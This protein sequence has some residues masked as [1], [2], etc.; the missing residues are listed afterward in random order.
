VILELDV[1]S[2]QP[3]CSAADVII[4]ELLQWTRSLW[5]AY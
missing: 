5:S 4:L 1:H 2:G 3:I